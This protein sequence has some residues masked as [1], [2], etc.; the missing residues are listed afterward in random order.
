MALTVLWRAR[1]TRRLAAIF[2]YVAADSPVAADE[3]ITRIEQ[4]V[5]PATEQSVYVPHRP[6][7]WYPRDRRAPELHCDPPDHHQA[8]RSR[9]SGSFAARVPVGTAKPPAAVHFS[10]H[11]DASVNLSLVRDGQARIRI[12][13]LTGEETSPAK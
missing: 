9:G 2:D 11:I 8:R 12:H 7:T 3:L 1:A 5:I 4:S 10:A 13:F 6:R